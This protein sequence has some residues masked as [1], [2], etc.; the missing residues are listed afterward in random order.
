MKTALGE[1]EGALADGEIEAARR[2]YEKVTNTMIW[3]RGI[4]LRRHDYPIF[5]KGFQ[6]VNLENWT[7]D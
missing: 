1:P 3:Y 5:L 7:D 4:E 6:Q 2:F